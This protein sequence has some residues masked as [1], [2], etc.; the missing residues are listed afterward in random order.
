MPLNLRDF[1]DAWL[2]GAAAVERWRME[3][4]PQFVAPEADEAIARVMQSMSPMQKEFLRGINPDMW[5]K[6]EKRVRRR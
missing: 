4:E 5:K 6:L 1:D 2:A 3:F